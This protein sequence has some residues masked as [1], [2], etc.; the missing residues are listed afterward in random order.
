MNPLIPSAISAI[1][2]IVLCLL[3]I[4]A[5]WIDCNTFRIPNRLVGWGLASGLVLNMALPA[6]DGFFGVSPGA[7]GIWQALGGAGVGLGLL[8]PLYLTCSMGAGDV[9]LMSM[10]GAF[11]GPSAT[12]T[13]ILLSFILGGTLSIVIAARNGKLR[14]MVTNIYE[15]LLGMIIYIPMA[16][17][18]RVQQPRQSA[19]RMPYALV[20]AGGLFLYLLSTPLGEA[21]FV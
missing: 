7:L 16:G 13:I 12:L 10:I 21:L 1:G 14:L 15:M 18:S 2:P 5:A 3:V 19:G 11:L 6:G 20:I 4:A 17:T 9:K 8:F